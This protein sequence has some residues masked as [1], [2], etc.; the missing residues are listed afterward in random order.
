MDTFSS[1]PWTDW[2]TQ[3]SWLP[4]V[5]IAVYTIAVL[6]APSPKP[7]ESSPSLKNALFTWNIMMALFSA[8]CT[9]IAVPHYLF[10]DHGLFSDGITASV[11]SNSEWFSGGKVGKV[12]VAFTLSKFVEFG[13]TL[14]L[15]LRGRELT[16]LHTFH[17]AMT[18][19]L[20]WTLFE[21][22]A[23]T[24]L[25]CVAMNSFI[26]TVM[27]FYYAAVLHPKARKLLIPHSQWITVVQISQMVIGVL[28]NVL[29]TIE[30]LGERPCHVPP[31]CVFAAGALYLIYAAMFVQFAVGRK[32]KSA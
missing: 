30:L 32:L 26:H 15:A 5:S 23:S 2:A 6:R 18:L 3:T 4:S 31:F 10:G 28:V 9:A 24:G 21:R 7:G 20:T 14:F 17:H 8:W 13:D 12:A 29:A 25:V 27:Y 22:R 11:C 19:A 1:T 16:N